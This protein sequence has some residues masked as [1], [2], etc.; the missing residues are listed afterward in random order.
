MVSNL[1]TPIRLKDKERE[2]VGLS[3]TQF[4]STG[5]VSEGGKQER[6]DTDDR[7]RTN[8]VN[9]SLPDTCDRS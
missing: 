9:T 3:V 6:K 1:W 7:E 5:D 8:P 4:N 2:G